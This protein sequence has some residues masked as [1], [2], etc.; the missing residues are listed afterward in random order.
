M[1]ASK[2]NFL[3]T[4]V[5]K[6][7]NLSVIYNSRT[8]ALA[9]LEPDKSGSLQNFMENGVDI[10]DR[11]FAEQLYECGILVYDDFDELKQIKMDL[12]TSRFDTS[13]MNLTITPTMDCNFRCTYCFEKGEYHK[14][15][16]TQE[17][18]DKL[19]DFVEMR[20][21]ELRNLSVG[22][23]GGEPLLAMS[24]I[25]NISERLQ[26]ICRDNGITYSSTIITNGYLLTARIAKKLK[27]YGVERVQITI[28][29][30]HDIHNKRRPLKSGEGTF[31]TIL[32]NLSEAKG[33]I[34]IAVRINID[35]ENYGN[36]DEIIDIFKERGLLENDVHPYLGH[37]DSFNDQ[38][39]KHK[40]LSK[41]TYSK[42]N[43]QFMKKNDLPLMNIYPKQRGFYCGADQNSSWAIDSQGDLYKCYCEIG[44]ET[45]K[46]ASL[47][48]L[49]IINPSL[50]HDYMLHSPPDD[51]RCKNCK[52]LPICMGGCPHLRIKNTTTCDQHKYML[53]DYLYECAK[54]L[55]SQSMSD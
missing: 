23:F 3:Y 5:L 7:N 12:L 46:I 28:D 31:D 49:D 42:I 18:I 54:T 20:A 32:S 21:H 6:D 48:N 44:K 34:P 10:K 36:V 47:Y 22:W 38:Y 25:V 55:L 45:H 14:Q 26:S 50:L 52:Y 8:G 19:I 41:E 51:A 4:N 9:T 13:N 43:L 16:I 29:G 53:D 37:V 1:K 35:K 17:T 2:Y 24:Q 11:E 27:H 40:C 33:I 30:L 15:K 39:D